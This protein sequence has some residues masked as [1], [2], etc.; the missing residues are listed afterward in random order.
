MAGKC[1]R[2][3]DKSGQREL[4]DNVHESVRREHRE[5]MDTESA[6]EAYKRRPHFGETPFAVI[7]SMFDM[8][9]FLLRGIER[10]G[11]EWRWASVAFNLKKLMSVWLEVCALDADD[12]KL[13]RV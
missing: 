8:R 1:V 3:S 5:K 10:V 4:I 13:G 7:K 6:K 2:K 11:Q 9:R 12:P